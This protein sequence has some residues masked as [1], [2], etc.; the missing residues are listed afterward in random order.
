MTSAATLFSL[1]CAGV[2]VACASGPP[3]PDWQADAR[4]AMDDAVKAYLAGDSRG[5]A[6]AMGQA[7]AA[8]ARTGRP[9]LLARA[10]LMRCT[11]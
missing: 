10:E 8:L 3:P 6:L 5:D 11:Q 1:A 4:S 7:R 9:D 2:L